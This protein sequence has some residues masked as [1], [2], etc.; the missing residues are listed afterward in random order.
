MKKVRR[1]VPLVLVS[2][3]A[4]SCGLN[5]EP[6]PQSTSQE[7]VS[8]TTSVEE[9]SSITPEEQ[10][11]KDAQDR[12][13]EF[14]ASVNIDDYIGDERV[15]LE[16]LLAN[17]NTLIDQATSAEQIDAAVES[18][19]EY[20]KTAKTKADYEAEEEA[21]RVR[22]LEEK[23]AQLL[24]KV[25]IERQNRFR[26]EELAVLQ[27]KAEGLKT[28]IN[29]ATTMDELNA[30]SFEEFDGLLESLPS[31][32]DYVVD[33]LFNYPAVAG[34]PLVNEHA[35]NWVHPSRGTFVTSGNG[36]ADVGYKITNEKF[37]GNLS[38]V[39]KFNSTS[40]TIANVGFLIGNLSKTGTG[41]DGYLINYNF[42]PD[43]Q[44]LQIF[45]FVNANA[46]EAATKYEYVG[47]WVYQDS[48]PTKLNQDDI[49]FVYDGENISL[50]NNSQYL[51]NPESAACVK[52]PLIHGGAYAI[53]PEG[54]YSVGF[55]RWDGEGLNEKCGITL[56][57]FETEETISSKSLLAFNWGEIKKGVDLTLYEEEEQQLINSTFDSVNAV[58]NATEFNYQTVNEAILNAKGYIASLKT[59]EQKEQE[60][61]PDVAATI[62]DNMYSG[63]T[64]KYTPSNWDLVN[65][66]ALAWTHEKGSNTVVTDGLAGYVMDKQEH[67]DFTLV[68][69]VDGVYNGNPFNASVPYTGLLLGAHTKGNYFTG[70]LISFSNSWG[71][72]IYRY[73]GEDSHGEEDIGCYADRFLGGFDTNTEGVTYRL[74]VKSGVLSVFK[75]DANGVETPQGGVNGAFQDVSSWDIQVP[76]GNFGIYNWGVKSTYTISEYRDL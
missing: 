30:I 35:N 64:E 16:T 68:V 22:Q 61:H 33:E 47:G 25:S 54:E 71:F 42:A 13:R 19:K 65:E 67:K 6:A 15:E 4:S 43:H 66:H 17:L 1:I 45:H 76:E 23:R 3:L 37:S 55:F 53:D 41:F 12:A 57:E 62:L 9:T 21:E 28:Q 73:T 70:I 29:A 69:K 10:A 74:T 27:E 51:A 32:A 56:K 7:E 72:Q 49:K 58:V 52:V 26:A 75:I 40:D 44:Y 14:I 8:T 18:I 50:Y 36:V 60:R 34:W 11:L 63:D 39:L 20:L 38:G 31:N 2:L 59:H 46:I 5:S 24:N 48:F